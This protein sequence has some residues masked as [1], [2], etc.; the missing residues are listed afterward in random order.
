LTYR[1]VW[2][3]QAVRKRH[4]STLCRLFGLEQSILSLHL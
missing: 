4:L 2:I 3:P 1:K